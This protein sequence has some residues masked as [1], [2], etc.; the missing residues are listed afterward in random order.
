MIEEPGKREI[1]WLK[2]AYILFVLVLAFA[3]AGWALWLYIT[4]RGAEA[5]LTVWATMGVTRVLAGG[6]YHGR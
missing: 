2:L 5:L 6:W 1:P 4:D 3:G